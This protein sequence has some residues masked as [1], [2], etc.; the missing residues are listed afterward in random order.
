M[1][2][3]SRSVEA[4]LVGVSAVA[5]LS[6]LAGAPA[7][8][9]STYLDPIT[10][11]ASRTEEVVIQ[12][13]AGVSAVRSEQLTQDMPTRLEDVLFGVPGV[14]TQQRADEPGMA[15]NIRGLQDF[16]RV[17]VVI[18]GARQNFQ[19]TGH[20]ADGLVYMEPELL[21]GVDVVRGPVANIYGSG[22][23]GGVV[24]M[25]TLDSNDIL[26]PGERFAA[27]LHGMVGSNQVQG[28]GSA[29]VAARPVDN[30]DF[31][32]G[33]T[34]RNRNDF[35]DG[36]GNIVPNSHFRVITEIGKVNVRPAE[37][38]ELKFG[39]INYEASY[40]NGIPN[41]TRTATVYGTEVTNQIATGRWRYARPDDKLLDF[42]INT[43]W[44]TTKTEQTKVQGT[45]SAITGLLGSQRSFQ[46]ETIGVD[47]NNTS[48]FE[49]GDF[50]FAWT[51]G[52]DAFRDRVTVVDPSGT[53]DLFTPNGQRTVSGAF[54]QLRMNYSTWL[55][56]LG[57]ARYDNYR[58]E[59]AN[60]NSGSS[61]DR[62]S[63]KITVGLT[64]IQWI[65]VYGTYAEGYRAPAITEV[66][67]AGTHPF[68]APFDLLSNPSLRPEV[69]KN[70]EIGV[71]IRKDALFVANDAFRFK[72]NVYQND[73]KDFIEFVPI[74]NGSPFGTPA[75]GGQVCT[76]LGFGPVGICEQ[77]QN[78]PS[79]RIRGAEFESSYDAGDWFLNVAGSANKGQ[80]LTKNQPLVKIYP[81]Q[82]ATTVGARFWE[83]KVTMAVRWLAVAEKK[84]E[85]IP[86]PP[87]V[88]GFQGLAIPTAAYNVVGIYADYRPNE[89]MI[90]GFGIDNLFDK[91]YVRYLD[92]RTLSTQFGS[93]NL[94]PSPSPGITFKGSLKVRFGDTF[95]KNG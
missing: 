86:P 83:R 60:G 48:R 79:A 80:N 6:G 31:M 92:L 84:A 23:I 9:Q 34:A 51:N 20:Q 24:S 78:I 52:A 22:A 40:D 74:V 25:R 37:G 53:G 33:T 71:N 59:G 73:I 2:G 14:N 91:Y 28:L 5:L 42:D 18:D 69:G 85:D 56:V 13:L 82:L 54:T 10:V 29:F 66:F 81:P 64:P 41:A 90:I 49:T 61:G 30:F 4:L 27:L 95:F 94:V 7:L 93:N 32:V 38:H 15:V 39:F 63:P 19:R 55:E 68:P 16:G 46:V 36:N 62:V 3:R 76:N 75:Q 12:A 26:K 72:A 45:N 65:T 88:P 87:P 50:R 8:A 58:L 11:V 1:S 44:T 21:A 47:A 89:D 43:Y 35:K 57:A 67:V 77:Y 70:K 17:A